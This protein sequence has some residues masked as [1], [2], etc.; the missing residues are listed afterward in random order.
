MSPSISAVWMVQVPHQRLLTT[1]ACHIQNNSKSK[2]SRYAFQSFLFFICFNFH[3]LSWWNLTE[4]SYL[5]QLWG[6]VNAS[7]YEEMLTICR[8]EKQ[9]IWN[10]WSFGKLLSCWCLVPSHPTSF[11]V[12]WCFQLWRDAH[13]LSH[14]KAWNLE[15]VT[16]WELTEPE[17]L[18]LGEYSFSRVCLCC[19]WV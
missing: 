14:Q 18:M 16:I 4:I 6:F 13:Y 2:M 17:L 9:G 10:L 1:H 12:C 15:S 5:M 8:T 7:K 3:T 19:M 11:G